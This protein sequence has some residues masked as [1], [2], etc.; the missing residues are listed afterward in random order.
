MRYRF[1]FIFFQHFFSPVFN[2]LQLEHFELLSEETRGYSGSDLRVLCT[3][4]HIRCQLKVLVASRFHK[5][6]E[7][8]IFGVETD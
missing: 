5:V 8:L 4:A 7:N 3:N 1:F 6:K 2:V